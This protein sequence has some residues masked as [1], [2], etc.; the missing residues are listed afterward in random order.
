MHIVS[1]ERIYFFDDILTFKAKDLQ[2]TAIISHCLPQFLFLDH[3]TDTRGRQS[4]LERIHVC[5][6]VCACNYLL[7]NCMDVPAIIY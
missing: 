7:D 5:L 4:G 1:E 6:Q 3:I 2:N